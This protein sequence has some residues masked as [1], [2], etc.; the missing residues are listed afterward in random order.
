MRA[1]ASDVIITP[2][3]PVQLAGHKGQRVAV[4]ILDDIHARCVVIQDCDRSVAII[5]V[6]LLWLS[7]EH[8]SQIRT[9]INSLT[10][11]P[12]SDVF[13]ACTHT[14][15]GPDTLDWYDFAPLVDKNWLSSLFRLIASSAYIAY[16]A[17]QP[18]QVSVASTT[19]SIGVNRRLHSHRG[20]ER[21]PNHL[22]PVDS[23]L[24]VISVMSLDEKRIATIL[25]HGT[26]P[27][28]LGANSLLIS[29]DW[30]G[31]A[32]KQTEESIGGV[33]LFLNGAAGNVNPA[34]WTNSTVA[35]MERIG[36][37]VSGA[38]IEAALREPLPEHGIAA[39]SITLKLDPFEHP[40]LKRAQQERLRSDKA[41]LVEIQAIRLGNKIIIGLGGECLVETAKK[42][43]DAS[44]DH[45]ILIVSYAND[46]IGYIP[47]LEQIAEGGYEARTR[48]LS[49]SSIEAYIDSASQLAISSAKGR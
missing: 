27:V 43:T 5:S 34:V 21:H 29:G 47:T 24:D 46:Y 12:T 13:I 28:V 19:V 35:E 15:S 26:H 41:M 3:L 48:M 32:S 7:R 2:P 16:M 39:N 11:I 45:R 18:A 37:R 40:Y 25:R 22:G 17:L 42:I 23:T 38:A 20:V 9:I 49:E 10:G 6:E 8:I 33:C 30:C 36:R 4:G 1:G 31:V 44:V 14:H